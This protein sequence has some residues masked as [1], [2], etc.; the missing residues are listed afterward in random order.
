M[1]DTAFLEIAVLV[2]AILYVSMAGRTGY[3]CLAPLVCA[4]VVLVFAFE[5]G[6][7]SKLMSNRGNEWLGRISYSI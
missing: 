6:P 5:A 4:V 7:V 3:S 2:I 1:F